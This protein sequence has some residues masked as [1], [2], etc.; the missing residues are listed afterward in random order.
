MP[1]GFTGLTIG[2]DQTITFPPVP[3]LKVGAGPVALNATSDSGLPVEYYVAY[4]PAVTENGKLRIVEVPARAMFPVEVKVVAYQF[5]RGVEPRV[6]T[7]A[8]VERV[9]RIEKP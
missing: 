3:N 5:G 1:R 4:G 2:K 6:K 7:A 9:L 8:P